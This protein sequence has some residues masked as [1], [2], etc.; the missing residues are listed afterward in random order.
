HDVNRGSPPRSRWKLIA[1][2]F[3]KS[4]VRLPGM[5]QFLLRW[6][7]R[8]CSG[9]R[10]EESGSYSAKTAAS[11]CTLLPR[12]WLDLCS[13]LTSLFR[14]RSCGEKARSEE[15]TSELQ[16]RSDL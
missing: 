9:L 11:F 6:V 5:T 15:H 13:L 2:E 4:L 14:S 12:P 1:P 10:H 7:S 16:S 8:I 3:L